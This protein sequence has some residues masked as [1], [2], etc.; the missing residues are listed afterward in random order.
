MAECFFCGRAEK[1]TR[2]HL[3][4]ERFRQAIA[5]GEGLVTLGSSSHRTMGVNRDLL[6]E[7]D[8]RQMNVTSLCSGC[9]NVW[10]NSIEVAA[11]PVF[12]SIMRGEGFPP[13]HD[14]M[15]LAHWATVV[16][17]LS[18]ELHP[19][20][21]LPEM[22]RREIRFTRT[23]QP[24]F[25]STFFIWAAD[26]LQ[27]LQTSLFRVT[28]EDATDEASIGW[29]HLLHAGPL[30][31]I[32]ASPNL[33]GRIARVLEEQEIRTVLGA[34]SSNIIYVPRGFEEAARTGVGAP[35]HQQVHQLGPVM[36][37]SDLSYKQ[38]ENGAELLDLS[39][40][41]KFSD[42]DFSFDFEGRLIDVRDE[43][44]LDYLASVFATEN[45]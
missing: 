8:V 26:V 19:E 2:A 28:P 9:N 4:Q 16:A 12:E 25:Y 44:Q 18:S 43:L 17:A 32:S 45:Q 36:L 22:R 34:L 37:G 5:L 15:K 29:F 30:A 7:G 20:I 42:T 13:R 10:M 21:A 35:T 38:T 41:L 33:F 23:G 27:S 24:T 11:A 1:L 3:F 6:F 14:L 40:G 31:A 39:A